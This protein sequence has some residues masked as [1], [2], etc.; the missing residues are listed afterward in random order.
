MAQG[1]TRYQGRKAGAGPRKPVMMKFDCVLAQAEALV[2]E[3]PARKELTE[4]EIKRIADYF[5]AHELGAD[6]EL[7]EERIGSDPGSA[8]HPPAAH[9]GV[10]RSITAT[11]A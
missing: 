11:N 10:E 8:K 4:A 2:V 3:H 1:N 9:G 6:E 7:Q 5:Y